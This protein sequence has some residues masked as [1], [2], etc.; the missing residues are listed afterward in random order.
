MNSKQTLRSASLLLLGAMGASAF[1][2]CQNDELGEGQGMVQLRMEVSTSLTRSTPDNVDDLR[3]GCTIYLSSSKGLIFK[4]TGTD[5]LPD[6][7]PLM[8]GHYVAEAWAGDSVSASFDKK[9]YRGYEPFD[10]ET[11]EQKQVT[12][13]C[14]I[15]NVVA[16]VTADASLGELLSSYTVTV[17][18]SRESLEITS[19]MDPDTR[20]YFMMPNSD[21]SLSWS[22]DGEDMSGNSFHKEGV[23]ENV[24]RAHE[25]MIN[26]QYTGGENEP[27]GGAFLNVVIDD[28]CLV[29]EDVVTITGAPAIS[30]VG[31]DINSPLTGEPQKWE[32]RS[33]H[34]Q[35]FGTLTSIK[36]HADK[37]TEMGLPARDFD[38]A[39]MTDEQRA[40]LSAAGLSC[41]YAEGDE[42]STARI[43]L[44]AAMLNRLPDG[45]YPLE[46]S[47]T[48]SQGK[49]R[50]RTI[51]IQV[52]D[53][54]VK[55]LDSPWQDIYAYRA[56]LHGAMMKESASAPGFRYRVKGTAEWMEA[57][58]TASGSEYSATITGLTPG[59]TYEYQAKSA[60]SVNTSSKEFTTESIF[61]IPNADF[62][63]WSTLTSNSKIVLPSSSGNVEWWD[64]GN[65][66]S[67][68]MSKTVTNKAADVKHSGNYSAYL[69][70]QF[71]GIGSIGA[72]AAGNIFAGTF[73]G[74]DGTNGIL[75]FGRPFN[76][77]RPAKLAGWCYY[78]P[79]AVT[80]T[81]SNNKL[82]KGDMD[83]GIIYV[84]LTGKTSQI[85]TK[86]KQ[87]FDPQGA[88]IV[89]YGELI[90]TE[91]YG[92]AS[93]MRKFEIELKPGPAWGTARASHIVLTASASR[94]G[95]YFT[96]GDGSM[97]Y[98]DDLE[99]VY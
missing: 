15:A 75:T 85:L 64:T 71:V 54:D 31:F 27:F 82:N 48:D 2:S 40:Q 52:S 80:H 69:R 97:M 41:D 92:S 44:E 68:T 81:D 58:G 93:E 78:H 53:A 51:L 49:K 72:F 57:A 32:R 34:V 20:A 65:H 21:T 1:T 4:C 73:D 55:L 26:M 74:T 96:G 91:D 98:L 23:I 50:V 29:V 46:L 89:A 10:L 47:V 56:T 7:M 67:A 83:Q 3:D 95:D 66:G 33:V 13:N 39:A 28:R 6:R 24:Q 18:H 79:V 61:E 35:A 37:N 22:I 42:Y 9:F 59:T 94:Y 76:G 17:G 8:S 45:E 60:T 90:F 5:N 30:G 84:A 87:L 11:G 38:F 99:L 43:F 88:D 19:E 25:Y 70:S 77:S 12:V 36:V 86:T 62:E 14:T 63:Q 16:G